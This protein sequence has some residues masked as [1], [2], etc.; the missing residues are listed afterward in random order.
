MSL[1]WVSTGVYDEC[2]QECMQEWWLFN[3]SIQECMV[4]AYTSRCRSVCRNSCRYSTGVNDE[5][6]H[7][8]IQEC[9]YEFMLSFYMSSWVYKIVPCSMDYAVSSCRSAWGVHT[10]TYAGVFAGVHAEFVQEWTMSAYLHVCRSVHDFML[11]FD[12]SPW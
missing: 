2:I 3:E 9:L 10:R 11:T 8:C 5:C 12:R 4:S 7:E 6:T 1:C